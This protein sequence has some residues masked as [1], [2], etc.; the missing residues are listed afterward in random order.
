MTTFFI[1]ILL[2]ITTVSVLTHKH[3]IEGLDTY[4][5]CRQFGYT[6]ELCVTNPTAVYGP[7]SC[8]CPDG[9]IGNILPGFRGAC[10]CNAKYHY[11]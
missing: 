6:K 8:M 1:A 9:T 2:L 7:S 3:T 11:Y 4:Q 5:Q 10:I